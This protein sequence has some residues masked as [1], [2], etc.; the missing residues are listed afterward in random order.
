MDNYHCNCGNVNKLFCVQ[1]SFYSGNDIWNCNNIFRWN[2]FTWTQFTSF[3]SS[4]S[5]PH[6]AWLWFGA[7]LDWTVQLMHAVISW[8]VQYHKY[9]PY[10]Q[11]NTILEYRKTKSL[12]DT[13]DEDED[14]VY[15][16][17]PKE[18]LYPAGRTI[19]NSFI[20][21]TA[22]YLRNCYRKWNSPSSTSS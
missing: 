18:T 16:I 20:D 13:G 1:I 11:I 6:C 3:I 15:G 21:L 2:I 14:P 12:E 7:P 4:P 9:L 8:Q 22:S 19:F 10:Y 17:N 5:L